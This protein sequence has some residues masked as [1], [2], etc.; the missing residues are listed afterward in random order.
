MK[1]ILITMCALAVLMLPVYAT[2]SN[3]RYYPIAVEEYTAEGSDELRI[4]KVYQLSLSDDPSGIPTQDFQ[5]DG[6]TYRLLDIT[7]KD[8]V[9]VDTQ[10][11]IQN[12][13]IPSDTSDMGT[14]LQ[15]LD[16]EMEVTTEEGYTGTLHLDHTSIQVSVKGYATKT[17]TLSA[18]RTYSNLSDA[19]LSLIPKTIEDKGQTLTLADVKWSDSAQTDGEG[20]AV[21][22]YTATASYTGTTSSKHATGYIVNANYTGEVAKTD[23]S[24]VTYTAT[25]GSTE[26]PVDVPQPDDASSSAEAPATPKAPVDFAAVK[27]PLMI[28]GLVAVLAVGGVLV[29]KKIR[30]R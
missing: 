10:P 12:V 28:G 9:G 14:I 4:Q 7:R 23:C 21:T 15:K 13:T 11:C 26:A 16:A 8:E 2:E 6:R 3:S 20:G 19:D 30:R 25:F 27:R 18:T 1:R 22:R 17:G 24:V 5:R 29:V